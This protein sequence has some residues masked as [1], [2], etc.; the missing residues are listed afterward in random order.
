MNFVRQK[1]RPFLKPAV[2]SVVGEKAA[3]G[4]RNDALSAT[5]GLP[6]TA[7]MSCSGFRPLAYS[8]VNG[9]DFLLVSIPGTRIV[10]P[11]MVFRQSRKSLRAV[12]LGASNFYE[13]IE[14]QSFWCSTFP[15]RPMTTSSSVYVCE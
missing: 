11:T 6:V 7:K 1:A 14:L 4:E 15:C 3:A 13:D 2:L 9:T 8:K 12:R 5:E 10:L